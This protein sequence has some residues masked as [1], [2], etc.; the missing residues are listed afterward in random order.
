MAFFHI[1]GILTTSVSL[2]SYTSFSY[3]SVN[4]FHLCLMFRQLSNHFLIFLKA[5]CSVTNFVCH[6]SQKLVTVCAMSEECSAQTKILQ[7]GIKNSCRMWSGVVLK[8]GDLAMFVGFFVLDNFV[9]SM[10]HWNLLF[11]QLFRG[12]T[13]LALPN[14][15]FLL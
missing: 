8:E 5:K 2:L 4:L 13:V 1:T 12:V 14:K 10:Q 11:F 3:L 15:L 9:Y 7:S 6:W